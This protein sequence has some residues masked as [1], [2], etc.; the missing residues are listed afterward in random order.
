MDGVTVSTAEAWRAVEREHVLPAAVET[1]EP[2]ADAIRA[3]SVEDA[4]RRLSDMDDVTLGVDRAEFG[5]L[6]AERATEVYQEQATLLE[7]FRSI[8]SRLRAEDQ[9]LGLVSASRRD[10]VEMVL[11]RFGLEDEFDVIVSADDIDGP[12]KPDPAI[13]EQ[14][15]AELDVEPVRA[16]AVED[17]AHGVAAATEAGLYCI[18]LR[19][20]GNETTDLSAADMVVEDP[21]ALRTGL[22][23][24]ID[25]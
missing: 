17:S 19:G 13:Y 12:A 14:A 22:L 20:A 3:L 10:W 9:Q 16:T 23:E 7:G 15:T 25:K 6:Y 5:A 21:P 18:A 11:D 4:Y 8:L 2:P 24:R 1:G